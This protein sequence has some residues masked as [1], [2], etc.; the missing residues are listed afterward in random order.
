VTAATTAPADG[1]EST[2]ER[3]KLRLLGDAYLALDAT[4]RARVLGWVFPLLVMVAGGALRF[5]RL[6]VPHSLVFDET[7]YVKDGYSLMVHG[8]EAN[9]GNNPN[10]GFESGNTSMLQSSPEF[11]VHPPMGKWLIGLGIRAGGGVDSSFAWRLAAAVCGTLAILLIARIARRLFAS[12]ALGVVAGIFLAVDGEALVQSRTSLL[13]PFLMFW[14]LVAFGALVMDRFWFRRR[15]AERAAAVYDAGNMLAAGPGVGFRW[16]RL[17]A[18]VALGLACGTK[19]SGI[20]FVAVFGVMTVWWDVSARRAVG[21]GH[22]LRTGALRDGI[23]AFLLMVPGTALVYLGTWTGWLFS[24]NGWDRQ[25]AAD[26]PG[27]GIMWLPPALRSLWKNHTDMWQFNITLSTPHPYAANPLGWILQYRPTSFFYP[28]S[29]SGL[30]GQDAINA[31]GATSCSQPITSLGNPL[32]WWAGALA[33][34]VAL[35]W[36]IRHRDWRAGAALSGIAAGWL[37]WFMYLHRTIFTFY[38]VAFVP[39][40]IFTLV[41]V[42]GLIVGRPRPGEERAR[43]WAIR[44]VIAFVVIVV[45]VGAFFYPIWTAQVISYQQWHIRMWL[46]SWI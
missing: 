27:Q 33:M 3:L 46:Q 5:W 45:G 24:S 4:R 12:T 11:V 13:D 19:W 10:P 14:V 1:A 7:Y 43:R 20:Y 18:A 22:W 41:Y 23:P 26:N 16:W 2:V 40:V 39:W 32:I 34:F 15:L 6:G 42:L 21:V 35:Y 36:L 17:A 30:S 29:I 31:C 8:Y 38:S 44:G 37:P 28:T 9:W 25:W